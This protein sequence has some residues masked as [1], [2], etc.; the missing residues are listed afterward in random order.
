MSQ[1]REEKDSMG[2]V[3]IPADMLYGAQTERARLNFPISRL[4]FDRRFLFALGVIKRAAAEVNEDLG[5]LDSERAG[6]IKQAAQE[7][8]D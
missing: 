7:L 8:M 2:P 6:A 4:R 1:Y 3:R 5:L